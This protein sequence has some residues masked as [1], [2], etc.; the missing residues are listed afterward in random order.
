METID[1]NAMPCPYIA[2]FVLELTY[3]FEYFN[4]RAANLCKFLEHLFSPLGK[5]AN[6]AIYF[7]FRFFF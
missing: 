4:R 5:P 6:R 3:W 2:H 7:T 1:G